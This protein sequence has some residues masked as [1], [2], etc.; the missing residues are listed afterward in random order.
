MKRFCPSLKKLT[1]T[2][3]ILNLIWMWLIFHL[4]AWRNLCWFWY[5]DSTCYT[6]VP[7]HAFLLRDYMMHLFKNKISICIPHQ[8]ILEMVIHPSVISMPTWTVN[9]MQLI[10]CIY[11]RQ[12]VLLKINLP[13][14]TALHNE[15]NAS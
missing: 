1:N 9:G 6:Q 7:A 10:A 5:N 4:L 2:Y 8:Y 11:I 3:N 12:D 15:N 14:L 13:H